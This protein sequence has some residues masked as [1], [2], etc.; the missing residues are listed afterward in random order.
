MPSTRDARTRRLVAVLSLFASVLLLLGCGTRYARTVVRDDAA[1]KVQLRAEL[2]SGDRL[3][4]GYLHPATISGIRIS[5]IISRID[6]RVGDATTKSAQRKP[7]IHTD[8]IYPLGAVISEALEKADSSQE[9]VVEAIRKEKRLG[10]FTQ[11]FLTSFIAFVD[12]QDRLQLHFYRVEWPIPKSTDR[13]EIREPV[14]G[15][16]V[17]GFKVLASELIEPLAPQVVAVSW[18]DPSF[19]KASNIRVTGSGKVARRTILLEGGELPEAPAEEEEL[20][21]QEVPSD[22]ETLKALLRLEEDRRNG[23]LTEAEYHRRR[24]K[25]LTP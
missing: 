23:K 1:L 15:R 25:I 14:Q 10:I 5:H 2:E 3:D 20:P 12:T 16:E 19:R 6:V 18:R 8:L 21:V 4:H 24:R 11:S 13:D 22:P 17:M 9:V 7:A